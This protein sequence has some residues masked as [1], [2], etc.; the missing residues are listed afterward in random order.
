[1]IAIVVTTSN[2]APV[3]NDDSYSVKQ[4]ESLT[5]TAPG[6]LANDSD[7]DLNPLTATLVTGPS[8]G[9]LT[10][11][12]DGSFNYTPATA[13]FGVDGFTYQIH[14]GTSV[15]NIATVKLTVV[16]TIGGV[17]STGDPGS[18]SGS[19]GNTNSG[20]GSGVTPHS[21][22]TLVPIGNSMASSGNSTTIP[23]SSTLP[24]TLLPV[25]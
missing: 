11:N 4:T 6:V 3:A 14:D 16:Q 20:G 10:L 15:G 22:P 5:V 7:A 25:V 21:V 24:P 13:F 17:V 12:A 19:G 8:H 2:V 23:A 9:S 18:G 1:M